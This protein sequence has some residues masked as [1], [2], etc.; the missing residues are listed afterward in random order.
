MVP[1]I[2]PPSSAPIKALVT[3]NEALPDIQAWVHDTR[4][5]AIIIRG[6][7]LRNPYR[8]IRSWT[9]N[10]AAKNRTSWTVWPYVCLVS[11]YPRYSYREL[12]DM[13][14]YIVIVIAVHVQVDK[15]IVC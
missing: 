10:S 9:G 6:R 12:V 7:T 2:K 11:L 8:L 5:Q 3:K 1:G 14:A 15:E 13:K 4:L